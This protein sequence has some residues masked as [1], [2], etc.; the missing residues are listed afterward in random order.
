MDVKLFFVYLF[1]AVIIFAVLY[2]IKTVLWMAVEF[3]ARKKPILSIQYQGRLRPEDAAQFK[4]SI[5]N[6]SDPQ[7]RRDY[8]LVGHDLGL[9]VTVLNGLPLVK[10]I[11]HEDRKEDNSSG[12]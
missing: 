1:G 7:L 8:H 12:Q 4:E 2:I 11:V 5:D 9:E 6:N 10:K 3:F